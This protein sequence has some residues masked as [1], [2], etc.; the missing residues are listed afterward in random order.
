MA[1]TVYFLTNNLFAACDDLA[2]V[3]DIL[4]RLASGGQAKSLSQ[5]VAYQKVM[6]RCAADA[7]EHVRQHPLVHQSLG[8][9]RGDSGR[10]SAGKAAKGKTIIEIMRNQDYDAFQ[11]LGGFVDVSADGYQ[12]VHRTAVYAPPPYKESMKMFVFPNRND[13]DFT[14]QPWVGRDIATYFT[15]YVDIL[16]AFEN[17]GPCSTTS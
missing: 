14:P 9:R 1:Q 7:P 3:Q 5:V 12:I 17:F 4:A 2:V 13:S 6:E 8:L 15:V 11:G 10:H 16:N